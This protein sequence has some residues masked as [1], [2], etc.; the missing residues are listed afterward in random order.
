MPFGDAGR[1]VYGGRYYGEKCGDSR[2]VWR[3]SR[4]DLAKG[5]VQLA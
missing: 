2:L 5:G 3:P 1:E 4:R